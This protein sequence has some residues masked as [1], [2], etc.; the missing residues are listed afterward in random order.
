MF[1]YMQYIYSIYQWGSFSKAAKALYITQPALSMAVKRVEAQVGQPLF[2]R[3]TNPVSLTEAGKAYIE[4][5]KTIQTLTNSYKTYC[6]D[7]TGL[8]SGHLTVGAANVVMS[9]VLPKTCMAYGQAYPGITLQIRESNAD[10]LTDLVLNDQLDFV[11]EPDQFDKKLFTTEVLYE[12][13]LLL[14]VPDRFISDPALKHLGFTAEAI[15]VNAHLKPEAPKIEMTPF[16]DAPFI[17]LKPGDS[18]QT[19]GQALCHKYG[20]SP[21][22]AYQ[23]DQMRSTYHFADAGAGLAFLSDVFVRFQAGHDSLTYFQVDGP[24]TTRPVVA[25]YKKRRYL[26]QAARAFIELIKTQMETVGGDNGAVS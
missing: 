13:N 4:N 17:M 3:S 24:N 23:L 6:E 1:E 5:V 21:K 2:D 25:A 14:G 12:E 9:Y 10:I 22:V 19:R 20:F 7:L 26:S 11:V 8:K 18:T 16:K 15:K